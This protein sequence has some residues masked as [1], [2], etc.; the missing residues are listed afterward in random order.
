MSKDMRSIYRSFLSFGAK[1]IEVLHTKEHLTLVIID[2]AP[3]SLNLS[4]EKQKSWYLY[5]K[6]PLL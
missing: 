2:G 1:V 4:K 6:L 5:E 3:A